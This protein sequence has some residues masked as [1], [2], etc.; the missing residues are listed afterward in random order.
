MEHIVIYIAIIIAGIIVDQWSKYLVVT[1]LK[2]IFTHPIIQD[3]FHFTY[4]E[5]T[6]AAFSMLSGR[7]WLLIPITAI[8]MFALLG[9]LYKWSKQPGETLQ[10]I[11]FSFIIAGGFGNLIDRVRL[12]YVV[13]FI[14]VRVI[15]F[16]IFNVA[17]CFIVGGSIVFIALLLFGLKGANNEN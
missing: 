17:D 5:N 15:N 11:A 7:K 16:A 8:A 13:D 1:R 6:G 2:P 12:G 4:A 3:I 10:K 9:Y 14:D